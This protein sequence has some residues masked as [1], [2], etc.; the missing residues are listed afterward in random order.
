MLLAVVSHEDDVAVGGPDEARQPEGVVGARRGRLDGGHLVGFDA[1][2][3][4]RGVQ[5]ADAPQERGVH[6]QGHPPVTHPARGCWGGSPNHDMHPELTQ[7]STALP[8]PGTSAVSN[9]DQLKFC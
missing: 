6:L 4:G 3:L 7:T 1:A 8:I 9:Q 5:H 2:E